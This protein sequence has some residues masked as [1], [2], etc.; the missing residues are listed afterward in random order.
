MAH[1]RVELERERKGRVAPRK[2][3]VEAAT[4][5]EVGLCG[6]TRNLPDHRLLG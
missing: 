4:G 3:D 2:D 1:A 5:L 6:Q